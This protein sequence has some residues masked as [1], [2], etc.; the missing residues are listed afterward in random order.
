MLRV[1]SYKYGNKFVRVS[2]VL[3]FRVGQVLKRSVGD[4]KICTL[5]NVKD[6]VVPVHVMKPCGGNGV[7]VP[8]IPNLN[9]R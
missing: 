9:T 8:L 7:T 3:S 1:V 6:K 5:V 2:N 4:K